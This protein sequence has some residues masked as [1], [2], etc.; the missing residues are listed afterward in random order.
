MFGK[1]AALKVLENFQKNVSSRVS[2]KQFELPNL[3]PTKIWKQISQQMFRAGDPRI[4]K[5]T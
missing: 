2:F 3:P 1:T 5:C 4:F